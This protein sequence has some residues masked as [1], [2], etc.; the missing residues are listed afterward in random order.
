MEIVFTGETGVSYSCSIIMMSPILVDMNAVRWGLASSS[1]PLPP[2][3]L[4]PALDG[5]SLSLAA[6]VRQLR[7]AFTGASLPESKT[8]PRAEAKWYR[9]FGGSIP[10]RD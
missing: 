2:A 8:R 10:E 4:A 7:W 1:W 9:D 5:A 3:L 6:S